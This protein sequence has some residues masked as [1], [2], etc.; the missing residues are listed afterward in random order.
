MGQRGVL[1]KAGRTEGEGGEGAVW[2]EGGGD[3][4]L[5]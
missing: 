1:G 4:L 5:L 3:H 2:R